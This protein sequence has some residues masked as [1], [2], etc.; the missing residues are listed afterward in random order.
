VK[1]ITHA[2]V[3]FISLCMSQT[4]AW[5]QTP[6]P[7]KPTDAAVPQVAFLPL[8][9][10]SLV[11]KSTFHYDAGTV[12]PIRTPHLDRTFTFK[13]TTNRPLTVARLRGSCGC[14]TLLL[15]KGGIAAPTTR[16]E[17][18]EQATIHL[19]VNLHG[20][21]SGPVRK[22]VWV[23]GPAASSGQTLP[24][25][26][27]EVDILLERSVTF[28][29]SSLQF[30]KVAAGAGASQ[31][32]TVSFDAS[33]FPGSDPPRLTSPSP[34][35]QARPTGPLEHTFEDGKPQLQQTYQVI[36]SHEAHA[37]PISGELGFDLPP[38]PSSVAPVTRVKLL[39]SGE[40]AGALDVLPASVFFGSVPAGSPV[41]RSVV[42]STASPASSPSFTVT[43][44]APWLHASLNPA[45]FPAKQHILSITLTPQAPIGPVQCTVT[46]A[47]GKDHLDIPVVA[48]LTK[49]AK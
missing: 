45:S 49:P 47:L 26:T 28:L 7:A 29:P 18:G 17:P 16:L 30:G 22:Y 27:L 6:I 25:A 3:L 4:L 2:R 46:V 13:N 12:D 35:V 5:G 32:L 1:T 23:D 15:L 31:S 40:V 10:L 43:T 14:E 19:S 37:G 34:D 8:T 42:L 44:S 11:E 33:L 48:E 41:T 36:L 20:G 39:L 9:G 24:L 21:Q 38:L